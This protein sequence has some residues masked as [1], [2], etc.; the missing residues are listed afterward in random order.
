MLGFEHRDQAGDEFPEG[1]EPSSLVQ[2]RY[3]QNRP[4]I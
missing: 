3:R 1:E 2:P 4:R